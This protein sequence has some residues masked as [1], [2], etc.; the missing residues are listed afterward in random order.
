VE[1]D[2][3]EIDVDGSGAVDL[4]E[5]KALLLNVDST[6]RNLPP[7]AQVAGQQG[8]FLAAR[9]NGESSKGFKYFHKGS[10]AYIGQE[11]AVAQVSMLKNLLPEIAQER[12][13]LLGE[14]IILTGRLA[15]FVWKLLYLDMQISNRNKLQVGFDWTKAIIFGRDTS[16]F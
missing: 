10:M 3:D 4:D 5:F 16:R 12:L 8:S 6:L 7:T 15:E 11:K 2:F 13:P 1:E 14:D 9:W